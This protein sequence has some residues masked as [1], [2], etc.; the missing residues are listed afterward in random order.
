MIEMNQKDHN[1][2]AREMVDVGRDGGEV[3]ESRNF[4]RRAC[5]RHNFFFNFEKIGWNTKISYPMEIDIGK[6]SGLCPFPM[7]SVIPHTAHAL[8]QA[9]WNTKFPKEVSPPC[10]VA[11]DYKMESLC[12]L[13]SEKFFIK[14]F[15]DMVV[16][17]C[18]CS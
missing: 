9:K 14:S 15:D 13:K 3:R 11:H 8:M 17:S 7:S 18:K 16:K 10:C 2:V 6:C 1:L 5:S 12:L 4:E